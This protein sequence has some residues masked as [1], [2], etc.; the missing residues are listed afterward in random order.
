MPDVSSNTLPKKV[1]EPDNNMATGDD[2]GKK[3]TY[4]QLSLI[5]ESSIIK[6][7]EIQSRSR[8]DQFISSNYVAVNRLEVRKRFRE[9]SRIPVSQLER[10]LNKSRRKR[11]FLRTNVRKN[12]PSSSRI[13]QFTK[14]Y[15]LYWYKHSKKGEK[16]K[17]TS[18]ATLK[19]RRNCCHTGFRKSKK[20]TRGINLCNIPNQTSHSLQSVSKDLSHRVNGIKFELSRDVETNPGPVDGSK[21]IKAPY[22]QDNVTLFGLNAGSQCVAMSLS[23]LIY[24]HRNAIVSSRDLQNVMN[25]GNELY[26]SLSRLSKQTYFALNRIT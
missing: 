10:A 6:E 25:I 23:A 12:V 18:K 9:P 3:G 1:T 16:Q 20:I 24:N 14:K 5:E 26:S 17:S 4:L 19:C 2:S 21:T 13:R 7:S 11:R 22:S 15:A 8:Y